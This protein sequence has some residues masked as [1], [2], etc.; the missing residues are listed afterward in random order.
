MTFLKTK[1][2]VELEV[3]QEKG[4]KEEDRQERIDRRILKNKGTD[5]RRQL[6]ED[7]HERIERR[8]QTRE[9]RQ[10]RIDRRGQT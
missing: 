8:G 2:Q 10:E 6:R 1:S 4:Q 9:E 5:R 7:K 3:R